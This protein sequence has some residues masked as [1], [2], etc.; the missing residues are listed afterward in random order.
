MK[1]ITYK[2][3]YKDRKSCSIAI[4]EDGSV[5]VS[6]PIGTTD[7]EVE[8]LIRKKSQWI[9]AKKALVKDRRKLNCD[10]VMY[11]GE[12]Y[13]IKIMVEP[14]LKKE[15]VLLHEGI[16]YINTIAEER[17][18]KVL[19]KRFRKDCEEIIIKK[20]N[21]YERYFL[22][23]PKEIKVKEQKRRWGS[24]SYDDRLFFN[25]KLVMGRESALEYVVV[26]EMC[27]MIH[28]NHSKQ[29]WSLVGKIMP[30]YEAEHAWL[31]EN[32]Y[33]MNISGI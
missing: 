21:I 13:K 20:I 27:H 1:D 22:K 23:E 17:A 16:F 29:Y 5:I 11:L 4:E 2:L 3:S 33:L 10:E 19:E 25:W 8:E 14:Y 32:G 24:C 28:K 30:N 26:H 6:V 7:K 12:I 9:K 15:F 31:K 18:K